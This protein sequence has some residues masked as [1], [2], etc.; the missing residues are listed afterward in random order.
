M[1]KLQAWKGI[2]ETLLILFF[3]LLLMFGVGLSSMM[4]F[5]DR[6]GIGILASTLPSIAL[7]SHAEF[8]GTILSL[9]M[10]PLSGLRLA[11]TGVFGI[12]IVS[13]CG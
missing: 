5:A 7:R 3:F 9:M 1:L 2:G 11:Q 12:D 13:S 6:G 4:I 10:A 8:C